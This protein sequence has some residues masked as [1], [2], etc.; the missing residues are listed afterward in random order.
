MPFCSISSSLSNEIEEKVC[1]KQRKEL[2]N[3]IK[4]G[5]EKGKGWMR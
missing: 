1:V 3:G 4:Q 2:G 5:I